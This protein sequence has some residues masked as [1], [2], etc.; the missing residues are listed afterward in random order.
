[1]SRLH[2]WSGSPEALLVLPVPAAESIDRFQGELADVGTEL[3]ALKK[4]T[5]EVEKGLKDLA[6]KLSKLESVG[7][8]PARCP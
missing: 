1:M 6:R 2:P 8:S 7:N 4:Q 3:K 5:R